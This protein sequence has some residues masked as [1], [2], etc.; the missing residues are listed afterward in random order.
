MPPARLAHAARDAILLVSVAVLWASCYPLITIG[1]RF[2]PPFSFAAL[3]AL[4]AGVALAL[5]AALLRRP[6]P[7]RIRTWLALAAIGLGTT[8]LGFLGMFHAAEFVS[9]G[10]ATVIAN[11]QP[12]IAAI[13]AHLFLRER[14]RGL[15][16]LGLLLGFLGVV[17]ISLPQFGGGRSSFL[18]GLAYIIVAAIGVA[19][20]NV[21]MKA[22]SDR[23]D[24]LV[25]VAAQY[26]FGAIPLM[27]AALLREQPSTI[28]WSP[29]FIASF[30]GLALPGSALVYWLWFTLLERI[31]LSR[32]NAFTFLTPFLGL[33][34]GVAFF[35]ERPGF[36]AVIG[37]FLAAAG[38]ILVERRETLSAGTTRPQLPG[39]G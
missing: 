34:F 36:A 24:P 8:T 9:P 26:L 18:A 31:P 2:A 21:G 25:A 39:A 5:I 1:L 13:L 27:V 28:T 12:L 16:R 19:S 38:I 20:G 3:R 10:L 35:G 23:V 6:V 33:A 30:L 32:A 4:V 11:S 14:L 15:Q 22:L 17:V 7:R 29:S 37:L